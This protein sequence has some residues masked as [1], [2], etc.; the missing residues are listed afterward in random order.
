MRKQKQAAN[1]RGITTVQMNAATEFTFIRHAPV[2]GDGRMYGRR[3]VA[4]DCSSVGTFDALRATLS[5]FDTVYCSP[6]LRCVQTLN[7]LL[8][9]TR[10]TLIDALWE[11]DFG[12]WEGVPYGEL[13]DLGEMDSPELAAFSPP[14]GESFDDVCTRVQAVL[15]AANPGRTLIIAHAGPIRAA[16][17]VALGGVSTAL[18]FDIANLSVT[19]LSRLSTGVFSIKEV[20]RCI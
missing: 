15:N 18:R 2:I 9:E 14:N 17:S 5:Q 7:T 20:N 1:E 10:P 13:P 3:D 12:D 16:L 11:Q 8:P 6:A 4:A 19:R